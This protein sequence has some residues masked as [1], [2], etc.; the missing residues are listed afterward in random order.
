MGTEKRKKAFDCVEMKRAIQE[1]IYEETKGME[2]REVAE[3][4]RR[5]AEQGPFADLWRRPRP[6]THPDRLQEVC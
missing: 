6:Q 4:F 2:P 3:Y 1:R 5:R